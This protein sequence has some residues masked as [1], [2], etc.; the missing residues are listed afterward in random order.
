M[1]GSANCT[2]RQ[3]KRKRQAQE[4]YAEGHGGGEVLDT[5]V[6]VQL[7][8]DVLRA[9]AR[10]TDNVRASSYM[11]HA[12]L[13]AHGANLD[14]LLA[15]HGPENSVGEDGGGYRSTRRVSDSCEMLTSL[16]ARTVSHRQSCGSGSVLGLDDLVTTELNA[17][18]E[19]SEGLAALLD[20]LLALGQLREE[21]DDGDTRVTADDG[22]V[23]L[24][25]LGAGEARQE[26][27]GANEVEGGDTKEA[28]YR[29]DDMLSARSAVD[30][31]DKAHR[32]GS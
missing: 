26:G 30:G 11:T 2:T 7:R 12:S 10:D 4:T 18:D 16:R 21:R 24:L 3:E 19:R 13:L 17:L 32:L 14:I 5:L 22:N 23:S 31:R 27:R 29:L 1:T 25:G 15:V 8:L 9:H 20:N 6:G 28:T